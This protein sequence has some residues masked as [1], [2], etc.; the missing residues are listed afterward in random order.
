MRNGQRF[1]ILHGQ[2]DVITAFVAPVRI[3]CA[4]KSLWVPLCCSGVYVISFHSLAGIM[5]ALLEVA[6]LTD[7]F[8]FLP[9]FKIALVIE[10][11]RCVFGS[12]R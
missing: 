9:A 1:R 12:S 4:D 8:L 6:C 7:Y 2:D 3:D 11:R 5:F 10:A